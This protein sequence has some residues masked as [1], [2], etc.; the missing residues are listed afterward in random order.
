MKKIFTNGEYVLG[1]YTTITETEQ[2][3]FA[4][5]ELIPYSLVE[6]WWQ[7]D[8]D[9]NYEHPNVKA[10]RNAQIKRENKILREQ[11]YKDESDVLFFKSQR[12]EIDIQVWLDKVAEIK[13]RYP[14]PDD[15]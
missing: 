4:D 5:K 8:V 7:E 13:A 2:G 14:Y 15:V 1:A 6:G 12:N 10:S 9:D 11:A 3:Y